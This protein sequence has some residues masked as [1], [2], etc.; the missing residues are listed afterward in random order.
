MRSAETKRAI[1]RLFKGGELY[2]YKI[3]KQLSLTGY[4]VELSRL[5]RVL[6]EML[7]EELL[8]ARWEKSPTGPKRR[9]YGVGKKG[10]DELNQ[11]LKGAIDVV[12][13]FYAEY[14]R[15]I[16]PRV[17][18]DLI[19]FMTKGLKGK[20]VIIY[21][22]SEPTVMHK[23]L[24][25]SLQYRLPKSVIYFIKPEDMP[26]DDE[27]ENLSLLNG[28]F[29]TIPLKQDFADLLIAPNLSGVQNLEDAIKEWH[30]LLKSQGRLVFGV[31][32]SL[33]NDYQDPLSIGQYIEKIEHQSTH[34]TGQFDRQLLEEILGRYFNKVENTHIVHLTVYSAE[35]IRHL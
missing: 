5:Y 35:G 12:H 32:S 6:S 4:D 21:V 13:E 18:N 29:Q 9:M 8:T 16:A 27:F 3:H 28:S 30:R 1:L 15:K 34:K 17:L 22:V 25:N 10:K 19:R 11:M 2:G 23:F 7:K 14:L 33:I 31:P 24:I 20:V 26:F